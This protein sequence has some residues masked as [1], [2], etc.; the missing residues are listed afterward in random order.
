MNEGQTQKLDRFVCRHHVN[1]DTQPVFAVTDGSRR[2]VGFEL[3]LRA[4]HGPLTDRP[5]PD[6]PHCHELF[7]G[8]RSLAVAVLPRD[9]RASRYEIGPYDHALHLDP[10]R[11]FQAEVVLKI[12]ILGR[13][14]YF[15]PEEACE[16]RCLQEIE[17]KLKH[18]GAC[19]GRW[20]EK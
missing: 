7:R 17:R 14:D 10:S 5:K 4:S 9:V 16:E 11:R 1:W 2:R 15:H 18:L 12:Q 8:L 3:E 13:Q 6:C 20:V 19:K